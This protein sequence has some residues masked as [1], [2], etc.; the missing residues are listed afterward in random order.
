MTAIRARSH[1]GETAAAHGPVGGVFAARGR[2]RKPR[3]R[4]VL[5]AVGGLAL[6]AGVLSLLRVTPHSGVGAPGTAEAEP[7]LDPG[8]GATGRAATTAAAPTAVPRALPTALPSATSVMGGRGPTPATSGS[9][10]VTPGVPTAPSNDAVVPTTI[11]T[12]APSTPD[13]TPRP[14]PTASAPRP[15]A[16]NSTPATTTTAAT[17][18][19]PT[20]DPSPS[21]TSP[22][23]G[24][25]C[26]PLIGLCVDLLGI[27][28]Q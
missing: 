10:S 1:V 18:A 16:A 4:K 11:P 21:P 2:H 15:V 23:P 26:L 8:G 5:L 17:T 13:S 3:P 27:G 24:G 28:D 19:A 12:G 20:P 22:D 14:A 9:W 7:R 25:V 6:A